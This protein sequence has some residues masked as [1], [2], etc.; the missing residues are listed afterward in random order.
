[1]KHGCPGS[2]RGDAHTRT[3]TPTHTSWLDICTNERVVMDS[4][5]VPGWVLDIPPQDS[6]NLQSSSPIGGNGFHPCCQIGLVLSSLLY[7]L[8]TMFYLLFWLPL[9]LPLSFFF[10]FFCWL[11]MSLLS[12]AGVVEVPCRRAR[13]DRPCWFHPPVWDWDLWTA[14]QH[15]SHINFLIS[16]IHHVKS[17]RA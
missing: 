12:L 17:N 16:S 4:L 6:F 7:L 13:A 14:Q 9:Q 3:H 2:R 15:A 1:M 11:E 5:R 8:T 10:S